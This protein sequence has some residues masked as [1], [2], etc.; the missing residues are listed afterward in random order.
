MIEEIKLI[1]W[2]S[3]V[4]TSIRFGKS[5]LFIGYIGSG[6][7][8]VVE[9]ISF[10]LFGT[11]PALR[12]RELTIKD[13]IRRGESKARV[14][15]VFSIN[16]NR[17]RIIREIRKSSSSSAKLY[18]NGKLLS[19][20]TSEINNYIEKEIGIDAKAFSNTLFASQ[21]K[22]EELIELSPSERRKLIDELIN[23]ENIEKAHK[24][25]VSLLN[26]AQRDLKFY[27]EQIKDKS[28][29]KEREELEKLREEY[30]REEEEKKKEEEEVKEIEKEIKKKEDVLKKEEEKK[31]LLEEIEK[32]EN[33]LLGIVKELEEYR[34]K[35]SNVE[36]IERELREKMREKEE[37]ERKL[38]ERRK[39]HVEVNS[40]LNF[41][42]KKVEEEKEKEKER[43][44]IEE[45]IKR[46]VLGNVESLGR[47]KEKII[48]EISRRKSVIENSEESLEKIKKGE[49]KCPVCLKPLSE[50]EKEEIGKH[51]REEI[52]KNKEMV[53]RGK[54]KLEE[55]ERKI[56]EEEKKR[57][58]KEKL[59]GMLEKI[60]VG[61][62]S[63]LEGDVE[64]L[65]REK[66]IVEKEI[67][68]LMK[69]EKGFIE[70]IEELRQKKK[71]AVEVEEKKKKLKKAE[72][73]LKK[74][75]EKKKEVKVDENL[76]YKLREDLKELYSKVGKK[77]GYLENIKKVMLSHKRLIEEKEENLRRMEKIGEKISK[78]SKIVEDLSIAKIVIEKV[79]EEARKNLLKS[80]N[81]S[82]NSLWRLLYPYNDYREVEIKAE[83]NSY[84]FLANDGKE[85]V[86]VER[87]FSGG[88]KSIFVLSL[89]LAIAS[90]VMSKLRFIILD[91]PTHNLDDNA[92]NRL[93]EV[94]DKELPEMLGQF[95]IVT[96]DERLKNIENGKIFYFEREKQGGDFSKVKE[97]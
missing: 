65:G 84:L 23:I 47:E 11:F 79:Q 10:L 26:R 92:V 17:L 12:E 49:G 58:E 1:N 83:G 24:N 39:Y 52:I 19:E 28:V 5:N 70:A 74:L 20:S 29:E 54:E 2:T 37:V 34:K 22:L 97:V 43:K 88:E 36:E 55:V 68:E 38:K 72:E 4:N 13:V 73:L 57:R 46:M 66:G 80:I 6:K 85:W 59:E 87:V 86:E 69:R 14:E 78:L 48:E 95:I 33:T 53:E 94:I 81:I 64:R 32:R 77:K 51:W 89:R 15:G 44:E 96:H 61:D 35:E 75:E 7:S 82:L 31:K 40:R 25:S 30:K 71:R 62:I 21:N 27:K 16:G 67:E 50:V 90:V 41:I 42:K 3:H 91:E 9:A 63:K 76:I 8:S 18:V 93:A 56:K 45:K 60:K